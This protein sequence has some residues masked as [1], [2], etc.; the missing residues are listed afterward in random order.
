[1]RSYAYKIDVTQ[2]GAASVGTHVENPRLTF[3][4]LA[5]AY[6]LIA[7]PNEPRDYRLR[8]WKGWFG[9]RVAWSLTEPELSA[10][11]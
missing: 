5:E 4:E 1:M 2:L 10:A 9:E 3:S 7:K 8:K 11:N 6:C